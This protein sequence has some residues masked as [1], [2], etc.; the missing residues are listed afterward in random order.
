VNTPPVVPSLAT[1][2]PPGPRTRLS[3]DD[4]RR[5]LLHHAIA[6]F[7]RHGFSGTR[8]KD[9][10][11]ACGVSEAILFRHF[12]T[13][14][15]LYHAILDTHEE[16]AGQDEWLAEM[17]S[18]ADR[19]DDLGFIQCLMEHILKS[20]REDT[21]FHRL[22]LYAGLEGQSL[23]VLFHERSGSHMRQVIRNYIV[24][25]QREGAF[26]KG[27]ADSLV[28]LL[29]AP[30]MQYAISKYIFRGKCVSRPDKDIA[31]EF[32]KLM[33]TALHLPVQSPRAS[34]SSK[35]T[36]KRKPS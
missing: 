5:Q 11:A 21:A 15:D 14:E 13:K 31:E 33:A 28:L 2:I 29:V 30:A 20:F 35:K 17:K 34:K 19:R 32:A 22:M 23:P 6:L 12:A 25:R 10:A 8:T 18:R 9:I 4:R 24:L 3:S 36:S 26:P 7:S 1:R 16:V 27:N